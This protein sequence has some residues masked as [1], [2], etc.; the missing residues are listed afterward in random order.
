[1]IKTAFEIY[2]DIHP[3]STNVDFSDCFT[4]EGNLIMFWFNTSDNSTHVLTESL[5]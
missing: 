5:Q 1:M 2:K 4:T 3:C